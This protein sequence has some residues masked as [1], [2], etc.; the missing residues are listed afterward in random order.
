MRRYLA[1]LAAVVLACSIVPIGIGAAPVAAAPANGFRGDFELLEQGSHRVVARVVA[2]FVEP[3]AK[4]LVPGTLDIYWTSAVATDPFWGTGAPFLAHESHGQVLRAAF[5]GAGTASPASSVQGWLCDHV[6]PQTASCHGF[7]MAFGFHGGGSTRYAA[8]F[9]T[10]GWCCD[11]R[12]YDVGK[13]TFSLTVAT[14]TRGFPWGR[15][16]AV[17]TPSLGTLIGPTGVLSG[18]ARRTNDGDGF[19]GDA[20][21]VASGSPHRRIGHMTARLAGPSSAHLAPGSIDIAW[22]GTLAAAGS[23][24]P[25]AKARESH[26][27]VL[28]AAYSRDPEG[29]VRAMVEG[30]MCDY[31]GPQS[32]SCHGFTAEIV[33]TAGTNVADEI[34]FGTAGACCGGPRYIAGKGTFRLTEAASGAPAGKRHV[35]ASYMTFW[36]IE[37]EG[38]PGMWSY[39]RSDTPLLGAYDSADPK[40]AERHIATARDHGIDLFLLDFGWITPGSEIDRAARDGLLRAANVDRIDIALLYFPDPVVSP[41]WGEGPDRFRSDFAYMAAA[42][43]THPSYLRLDGRPV[44][45][46]N[47]LTAY[48]EALG[49]ETTNA[50]FA[51]AKKKYD[52]YLIAGMHPD[53][54]PSNLAGSPFDAYTLWGNMWGSLGD[55]PDR[56]YTYARYATAYRDYW[57]R[58]HDVAVAAGRQFVPSV[59]PGF[60]N[61]AAVAAFDQYHYVIGR[62]LTEFTSLLR[63]V[64]AVTTDPLAMT[65]FFSWNDFSEGHAIE[66]SERDGDAYL[67]AVG[68]AFGE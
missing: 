36:G 37:P 67:E 2:R 52:L 29:S 39:P 50:L 53:A 48:W 58:W 27:R 54:A 35:G 12:W 28:R 40:V 41:T 61:A 1:L 9:G 32:G 47:G 14:N 51:E 57:T 56:T 68:A 64:R 26:G 45:V 63:T 18:A 38:T 13:G 59:Y 15:R 16:P 42:Y 24:W 4:R 55:D 49:V 44:V 21:L 25:P 46:F 19:V 7:Q 17:V 31:L 22:S 60:D 6:W 5:W 3:T 65:L 43:F 20:D 30:I 8:A 23:T 66:P 10:Y 11:G 33:V 34:R 62:D